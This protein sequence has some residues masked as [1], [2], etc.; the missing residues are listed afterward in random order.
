MNVPWLLRALDCAR[1]DWRSC[2]VRGSDASSR[3]DVGV[4]KRTD[5]A[6]DAETTSS[7]AAASP[8][9]SPTEGEPL[10]GASKAATW[11]LGSTGV[12]AATW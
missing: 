4:G 6:K 2:S 7:G 8:V 1:A 11:A 9:P 12:M 10:V 3:E 5:S